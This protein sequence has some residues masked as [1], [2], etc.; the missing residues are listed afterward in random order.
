M[1]LGIEKIIK[2]QRKQKAMQSET[3]PIRSIQSL[4]YL[5]LKKLDEVN[6]NQ[7]TRFIA[8]YENEFGDSGY[9]LE[10]EKYLRKNLKEM[11]TIHSGLI[12]GSAIRDEILGQYPRNYDC[13]FTDETEL[14][15]FKYHR[16]F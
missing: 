1:T 3:Q 13:I 5:C 10:E 14:P 8:T 16:I 7:V 12:F 11:I 2:E 4:E 6:P 15:L 9:I